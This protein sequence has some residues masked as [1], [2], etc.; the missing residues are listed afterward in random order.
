MAPKFST[1]F[2]AS[3]VPIMIALAKDEVPRV[4][5]HSAN[6]MTNFL[7]NMDTESI[8]PFLKEL[9]DVN[10]LVLSNGISIEK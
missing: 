10:F 9:V 2:A 7:E 3:L 8:R 5:A 1:H 6:A 4:R